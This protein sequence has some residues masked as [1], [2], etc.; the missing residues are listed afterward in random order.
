MK[1]NMIMKIGDTFSIKYQEISGSGMSFLGPARSCLIIDIQEYDFE[2]HGL[3]KLGQLGGTK[4]MD[5][6]K[7][8]E[9]YI[10]YMIILDK[11][12][13]QHI[14]CFELLCGDEKMWVVKSNDVDR[15]S[16]T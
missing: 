8:G 6:N 7:S 13:H 2:I 16:I 3:P 10:R 9:P 11:P 15:V 14:Q 5:Y 12:K 4:I 1:Y